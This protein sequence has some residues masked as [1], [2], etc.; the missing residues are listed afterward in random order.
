MKPHA[1]FLMLALLGAPFILTQE[2]QASTRTL[3]SQDL[4]LVGGGKRPVQALR[5]WVEAAKSKA[6]TRSP[7]RQVPILGAIAW[8]SEAPEEALNGIRADLA[9]L[10]SAPLQ[11]SPVA[12][13]IDEKKPFTPT[14]VRQVVQWL[15]TLD[16]LYFTGGDQNRLIDRFEKNPEIADTVRKRYQLGALSLAGTSAGTAIHG[17]LVFTGQEDLTLVNPHLLQLRPGLKTLPG[18]LVDQHFL[19]RQRHNR[20]ISG[21]LAHPELTGL[22]IDEDTALV[23]QSRTNGGWQAQV[24]GRGQVLVLQALHLHAGQSADFQMR[25]QEPGSCFLISPKRKPLTPCES[26]QNGAQ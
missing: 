12:L 7:T 15:E 23:L 25:F 11:A 1:L 20:L 24:W 6:H 9:Q 17:S 22:A 5:A 13:K 8:A 3:T 26:A 10:T 2:T 16:G 14:E 18:F 19:K 4:V 21:V